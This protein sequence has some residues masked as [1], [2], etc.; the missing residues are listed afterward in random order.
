MPR[1]EGMGEMA[2]K[3]EMGVRQG[4]VVLAMDQAEQGEGADLQVLRVQ[5]G[6]IL[7]WHLDKSEGMVAPGAQ[8]DAAEMDTVGL[9]QQAM[10]LQEPMAA[11]GALAGPAAPPEAWAPIMA[12]VVQGG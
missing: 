9:T 10:E 3:V 6:I 1:P 12:Q 8:E 4:Y 5:G 7:I 2:V 11:P